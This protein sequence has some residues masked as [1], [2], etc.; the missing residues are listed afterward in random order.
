[1]EWAVFCFL[2]VYW[3]RVGMDVWKAIKPPREMPVRPRP[4][5]FPDPGE[6]WLIRSMNDLSPEAM[7]MLQEWARQRQ[8]AEKATKWEKVDWKKEGF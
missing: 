3:S 5:L 7:G 8:Q 1:M 4:S 6:P 2:L